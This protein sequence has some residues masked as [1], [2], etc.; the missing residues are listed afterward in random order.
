M[1][2][3][4]YSVDQSEPP[5]AVEP[6]QV[7]VPGSVRERVPGAGVRG[8]PADRPEDRRPGAAAAFLRGGHRG[9]GRGGGG[10]GC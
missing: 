8:E 10:V 4:S 7:G 3:K 6:Y 1:H 2:I 9:K 5:G